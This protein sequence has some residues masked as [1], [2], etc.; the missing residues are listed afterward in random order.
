MTETPIILTTHGA[1]ETMALGE[2]MGRVLEPGDVL[3]LV[4][5]LGAGKTYLVKGVAKG[6]GVANERAVNSPTFVLVNEYTGRAA[7]HHLDAYRL[8]SSDELLDLGFEE[9][10]ADESIA[11]VE[12]ADRTPDAI[13]SRALWIHIDVVGDTDR[14]LRLRTQ[15][16]SLMKRLI[17]SGLTSVA[18]A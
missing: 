10:C 7:I 12:W 8:G 11:I 15:N 6:L 17:D 2:R 1:D 18:D 3:A 9:M 4:G 5:Q 13:P 16:T 14:R